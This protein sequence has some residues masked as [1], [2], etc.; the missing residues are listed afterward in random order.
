MVAAW[1]IVVGLRLAVAP[2]ACCPAAMNSVMEG[3]LAAANKDQRLAVRQIVL[4][5]T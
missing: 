4:R 1:L 5:S 2:W 3:L